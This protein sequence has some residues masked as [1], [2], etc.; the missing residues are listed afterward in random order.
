[1]QLLHNGTNSYIQNYTGDLQINSHVSNGDILFRADD[2]TGSLTTYF[3]LNGGDTNTNF[4]LAT[5]HP[6]NVKAKFGTSADLEIYHDGSNSFIE[7]AG[8][9]YVRGSAIRLQSTTGEN[10]I[11]AAQDSAVYIYHNNVKKFETTSSGVA[12]T[13]KT[14]TDSLLIGSGAT[15]TTILDEDNMSSDSATALATQQSIKA[16]I[17]NSTT[18][19][20]TYQGTWN[21]STNSPTLSSGSGTPGYYYI[22]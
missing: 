16:Y 12:V 2:G 14:D 9:L 7:D 4:Q 5:L 22:V 3:Y 1:M 8:S 19:V 11:Y 10:M 21:A 18:G 6:D 15:V 20:L 17:D 13:G